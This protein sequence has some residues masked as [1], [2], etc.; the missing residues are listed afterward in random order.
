M[1][2]KLIVLVSSLLISCAAMSQQKSDIE[3]RLKAIED[4]TKE[5]ERKLNTILAYIRYAYVCQASIS[6]KQITRAG[7]SLEEAKRLT[8]SACERDT[9][10]PGD[11][12]A[13][14]KSLSC[15]KGLR[16]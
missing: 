1:K 14:Q 3:A 16:S 8:L 4:A 12:Q 15:E 9:H 2:T 5:N 11:E 10:L 13:C 7:G 6:G